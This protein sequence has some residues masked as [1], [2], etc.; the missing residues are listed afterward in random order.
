MVYHT[1]RMGRK[2]YSDKACLHLYRP[3]PVSPGR[4]LASAD[5]NCLLTPATA[6]LDISVGRL[7]VA[8]SRN[9]DHTLD[10]C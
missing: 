5:W 10:K 9:Q 4:R 6:A 3:F 8:F 7:G 2:V 1:A